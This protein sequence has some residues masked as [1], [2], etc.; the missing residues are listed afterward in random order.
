MS[1]PRCRCRGARGRSAA[2]ALVSRWATRRFIDEPVERL[3]TRISKVARG[4]R[5]SMFILLSILRS[6]FVFCLLRRGLIACSWTEKVMATPFRAHLDALEEAYN[7]EIEKYKQEIV[8]LKQQQEEEAA[9]WSSEKDRCLIPPNACLCPRLSCVP[10][11]FLFQEFITLLL[12]TV[13]PSPVSLRFDRRPFP[14]PELSS[15]FFFESP[16]PSTPCMFLKFLVDYYKR[17]QG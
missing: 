8:K 1:E 15:N 7:S 17:T 12:I 16:R 10:R 2:S 6:I 4:G 9:R 3:H 13:F 14:S 5:G 11:V